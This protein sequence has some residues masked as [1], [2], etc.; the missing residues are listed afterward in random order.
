MIKTRSLKK[1]ACLFWLAILLL[2]AGLLAQRLELVAS[3]DSLI[4]STQVIVKGEIAYVADGGRGLVMLDISD[5]TAPSL[6]GV[7]RASWYLYNF[8]IRDTLAYLGTGLSEPYI[9]GFEIVNIANP[10]NPVNLSSLSYSWEIIEVEVVGD[11]AYLYGYSG[12]RVIDISNPL[13][14]QDMGVYDGGGYIADY[15]H[16]DYLYAAEGSS[17]MT[18][19]SLAD[20][21]LPEIIGNCDTPGSAAAIALNDSIP[22]YAYIADSD[23]GLQLI[24]IS[25]PEI[26]AVLNSIVIPS[27]ALG[28]DVSGTLAYVAADSG[29]F[30]VSIANPE[31][32]EIIC[33][34]SLARRAQDVDYADGYIYIIGNQWMK[35]FRLVPDVVEFP[36]IPGDINN[37]GAANGIDVSYAVNFFKGGNPPPFICDCPNHDSLYA[38]G[39]VNGSCQFNGVDIT[40]F[41]RYAIGGPPLRWCIDCPPISVYQHDDIRGDCMGIPALD[42]SSYMVLEVVGDDLHIHHIDA[43]YQCCLEYVVEFNVANM[44]ITAMENDLGLPCDCICNFDLE[45]ILYDLAPGEYR[46]TLINIFNQIV[47]M[48]TVSIGGR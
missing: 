44:Q 1:I 24:E 33:S 19:L 22:G 27:R 39:D 35:I 20:P 28:I 6:M 40:Y 38:A 32:L 3:Y 2:P 14:P 13:T 46:V 37:N 41:V 26:P 43:T 8:A 47:G 42:D 29:L 15:A 45:S 17:G 12:S 34:S 30:V 23:S 10:S 18:V 48:D 16:N 7:Y 5:K 25:N 31:S 11:Y 36:Y 21:L 4:Y 9:G